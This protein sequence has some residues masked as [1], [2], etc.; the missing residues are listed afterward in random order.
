MSSNPIY[1]N[2]PQG[3]VPGGVAAQNYAPTLTQSG[4]GGWY[5][6]SYYGMSGGQ[7]YGQGYGM[8]SGGGGGSWL[9]NA[10]GAGILGAESATILGMSGP[11][12]LAVG[13]GLSLL[14]GLIGALGK[15]AK[16]NKYI[17]E[18]KK[19]FPELSKESFMY[20]N[21]ELNNAIQ[22]TLG[23]KMSNMADWGMPAGRD[24]GIDNLMAILKK[25]TMTPQSNKIKAG[26]P[27][28]SRTQRAGGWQQQAFNKRQASPY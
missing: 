17:A 12:G 24:E 8:Q 28:S 22:T 26:Q 27:Q 16:R 11:T 14:T 23:Q 13:V 6:P 10:L 7:S 5:P 25:L 2:L 20:K 18:A 4:Q 1:G 21:P 19:L 15:G 3:I 9:N